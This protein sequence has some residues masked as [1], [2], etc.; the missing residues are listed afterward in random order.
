M[1]ERLSITER[2]DRIEAMMQREL[3]ATPRD[4]TPADDTLARAVFELIRIIREI[5]DEQ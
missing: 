5:A 3:R 1:G 4:Y 2:L